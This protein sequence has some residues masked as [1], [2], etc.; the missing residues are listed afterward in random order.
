MTFLGRV[1]LVRTFLVAPKLLS[2]VAD[3][4]PN[5]P[6]VPRLIPARLASPVPLENW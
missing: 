6:N 5:Q 4:S 1:F 3:L 2:L